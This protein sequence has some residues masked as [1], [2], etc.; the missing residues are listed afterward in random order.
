[1]YSSDFSQTELARL[2]EEIF[3]DALLPVCYRF[4]TKHRKKT[5]GKKKDFSPFSPF[6]LCCFFALFYLAT[7]IIYNKF[8]H[9]IQCHGR[10]QGFKT[11]RA[12][13]DI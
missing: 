11:L 4:N 12:Y 5:K 2:Q 9:L 7:M 10:V 13:H 1:L 8:N 3:A 6:F